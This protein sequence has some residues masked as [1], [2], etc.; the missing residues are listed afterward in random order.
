VA[1][2]V[3]VD[4]WSGGVRKIVA[5]VPLVGSPALVEQEVLPWVDP[6]LPLAV[7]PVHLLGL[8]LVDR[9]RRGLYNSTGADFVVVDDWSSGV[10]KTGPLVPLV[11]SPARIDL[12]IPPWVEPALPLAVAP[13]PLHDLSPIDLIQRGICIR[14][15]AMGYWLTVVF[16][17]AYV[18][19]VVF[20]QLPLGVHLA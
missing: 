2:L 10:R 15:L 18:L 1:E 20:R 4:D 13:D 6:M 16:H 19:A 17:Q 7:A 11:G 3:V 5:L 8:C 9:I 14:R 12:A